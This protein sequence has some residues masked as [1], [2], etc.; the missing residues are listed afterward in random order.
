MNIFIKKYLLL[1][2]NLLK[3]NVSF[4]LIGGYAVNY[5]GHNRTMR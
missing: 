3:G 4:M 2:Q 1:I 5:Y